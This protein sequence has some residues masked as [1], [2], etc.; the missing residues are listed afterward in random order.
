MTIDTLIDDL[1]QL[2]ELLPAADLFQGRCDGNPKDEEGKTFR[3][4]NEM[5]DTWNAESMLYGI[6]ALAEVGRKEKNYVYSVYDKEEIEKNPDLAQ[7]KILRF[8]GDADKPFVVLCAGGAYRSVCSLA[9]SIPVGAAFQSMGYTTFCVNYRTYA[10]GEVLFPKP[11]E[12]LARSISFILS[13]KEELGVHTE[14]YAL[15]GFSA[16]GNLIQTFA[17]KKVGYEKYGVKKPDI[18]FPVYP[19]I[20]FDLVPDSDKEW[21]LGAVFGENYKEEDIQKYDVL[22]NIAKDYPSCYIVVAEDDHMVDVCN[23]KMLDRKLTDLGIKHNL[24]LGE[25]GRHGFGDGR[26]TPLEGWPE[27]AAKFWESLE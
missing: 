8:P 14:K 18:L 22:P 5:F 3:E 12:D 15:G 9:E 25:T 2:P 26:G 11:L 27:R 19:A 17:L 4:L 23:S 7:V 16:G 6:K 21:F 10:P 1:K 13:H 24:E 20:S